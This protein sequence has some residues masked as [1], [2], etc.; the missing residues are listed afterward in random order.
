MAKA[1]S[2]THSVTTSTCGN[3]RILSSTGS[4]E[5]ALFPFTGTTFN[6][7]SNEVKKEATRSWKPLNTLSVTTRAIV[8]TATP[9][10]E[11]ALMRL[12]AWVLFFEK[13]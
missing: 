12:M 7:G 6:W 4:S 5:G 13:R 8:A 1:W 11:M 3:W 10:T 9:N 2:S